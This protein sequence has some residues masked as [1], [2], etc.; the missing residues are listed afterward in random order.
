MTAC[1]VGVEAMTAL[2]EPAHR[3]FRRPARR[4]LSRSRRPPA[5]ERR[6]DVWRGL[7]VGA[8][9]LD[10]VAGRQAVARFFRRIRSIERLGD[11]VVEGGRRRSH[12]LTRSSDRPTCRAP[13]ARPAAWVVGIVRLRGRRRRRDHLPHGGVLPQGGEHGIGCPPAWCRR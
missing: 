2:Y 10:G 11:D 4:L 9:R 12:Y 13:S 5:N 6:E 1:G 8:A 7:L 3:H